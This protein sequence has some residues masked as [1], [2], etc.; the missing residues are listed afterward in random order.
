V[1]DKIKDL[2][3]VAKLRD[4]IIDYYTYADNTKDEDH[5]QL[6]SLINDILDEKQ[7]KELL[8]KLEIKI[9]IK[10]QF[11]GDPIP[12]TRKDKKIFKYY[13]GS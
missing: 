10:Q 1:E 13:V 7:K 2:N 12:K 3:A 5:I 11:Q 9:K 6:T 8:A 4:E